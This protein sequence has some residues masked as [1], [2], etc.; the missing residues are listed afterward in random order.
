MRDNKTKT[1]RIDDIKIAYKELGAGE[2]LLLIM[3]SGGTMD[4]WAPALLEGL[5]KKY[6]VIIFDNRGMGQTTSSNKI[7]SIELFAKDTLGLLDHLNIQKANILGWSMGA[8]IAQEISVKY[9]KYVNKLILYAGDSGGKEQ[10]PADEKVVK[11]LS[12]T[13]GIPEDMIHL[14]P[15]LFPKRWFLDHPEPLKLFRQIKETSPKENILKQNKAM[16]NWRGSYNRLPQ[17]KHETLI[18]YGKQDIV[19]PPQNS[20]ILF[21]RIPLSKL[22]EFDDAG[23]CLMYQHPKKLSDVISSFLT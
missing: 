20:K 17:I 13:S 9:P 10:I 22:V 1:A 19:T 2:P 21:E 15:L 23:H 3:G 8:Y 18:L 11:Q 12:S 16:L 7:F 4:M 14:L 5:S 6:R